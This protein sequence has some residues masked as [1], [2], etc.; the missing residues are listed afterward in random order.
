MDI[1]P[2]YVP[3]AHEI[4]GHVYKEAAKIF[5]DDFDRYGST[6]TIPLDLLRS[7]LTELKYSVKNY[8]LT[9]RFVSLL[10]GEPIRKQ[11]IAFDIGLQ[12]LA[13]RYT[14]KISP[15]VFTGENFS[16]LTENYDPLFSALVHVLRNI[17][18]HAIDDEVSRKMWGKPPA[19]TVTIDTQRFEEAGKPWMRLTFTDDG[20]GLDVV[21]LRGRLALTRGAASAFDA[22]DDE[23]R[24]AIFEDYV[25]TRDSADE[26]AGRGV[27]MSSIKV[28]VQKLGG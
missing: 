10:M 12:E 5:G 8:V 13:E 3:K 21:R 7:F 15:C 9:E 18:A 26:L 20:C 17:V 14:R 11:L 16:I 4:L 25:S 1:L 23:I 6:R 27:G 19:L 28:E 24:Q 22:S 2:K